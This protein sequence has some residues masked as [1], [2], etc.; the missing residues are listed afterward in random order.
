QLEKGITMN[1][2][3]EMVWVI[4]SIGLVTADMPQGNDLCDVK[5]QDALYGC[6][7]CL[8]PNDRLTDNTFDRIRGARFHQVTNEH[9]VQLQ[10]LIDQGVTK[11]EINNFARRYG[12]RTNQGALSSFSRDRHHQTPQDAY[13]AIAGKV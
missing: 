8:V 7:N 13:H 12:L 9:F 10:T 1:M 2:D 6:R 3:N 4:T 11:A 5:K